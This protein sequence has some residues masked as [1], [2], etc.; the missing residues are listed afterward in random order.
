[1]KVTSSECPY[2]P[3]NACGWLACW[4][5]NGT[6]IDMIKK[7][8]ETIVETT[9]ICHNIFSIYTWVRRQLMSLA[10][11]DM[12]IADCCIFILWSFD[13]WNAQNLH[14]SRFVEGITPDLNS[15]QSLWQDLSTKMSSVTRDEKNTNKEMFLLLVDQNWTEQVQFWGKSKR[16]SKWVWLEIKDSKICWLSTTMEHL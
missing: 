13:H 1:M 7:I 10:H 9:G 6:T 16:P 5:E 11:P 14:N 2:S 15:L 8:N 12:Y 3:G 4:R